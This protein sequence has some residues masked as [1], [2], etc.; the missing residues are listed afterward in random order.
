MVKYVEKDA[1]GQYPDTSI[2]RIQVVQKI[3]SALEDG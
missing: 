1:Q 3:K 2:A